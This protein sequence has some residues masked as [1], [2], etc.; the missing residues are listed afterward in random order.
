MQIEAFYLRGRARREARSKAQRVP[1]CL[2]LVVDCKGTHSAVHDRRYDRAPHPVRISAVT[3]FVFRM[4]RFASRN[5]GLGTATPRRSQASVLPRARSR[6]AAAPAHCSALHCRQRWPSVRTA[7]PDRT[8]SRFLY[9]PRPCD[10]MRAAL[11]EAYRRHQRV[12]TV[13]KLAASRIEDFYI[14]HRHITCHSQARNR[15]SGPPSR[16]FE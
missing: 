7:G 12:R 9:I 3:R 11:Q 4:L 5:S 15:P 13:Q 2:S 14:R 10:A 6:H 1:P 8:E 16:T